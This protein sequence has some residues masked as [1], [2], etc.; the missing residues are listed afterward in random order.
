MPEPAI[1]DV[2]LPIVIDPEFSKLLPPLGAR[3]YVA[4]QQDMKRHGC[5]QPLAFWEHEGQLI[6]L[7][8]HQRFFTCKHHYLPFDYVLIEGLETREDAMIW[9]LQ[10][11]LGRRH[12][13]D[14]AHA[15]LRLQ[16]AR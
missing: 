10:N 4:L 8:G 14:E 12:L 9:I 6:L 3:A 15:A 13:T 11:A 2:P 16:Y 7:D 1:F 5:L